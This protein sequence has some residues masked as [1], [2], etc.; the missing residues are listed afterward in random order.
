MHLNIQWP[1]SHPLG[2]LFLHSGQVLH[3]EFILA[4]SGSRSLLEI[5]SS[6]NL[7]FL[8]LSLSFLVVLLVSLLP[9]GVMAW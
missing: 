2:A 6:V 5:S 8:C 7:A 4:L 3:P 9:R 1:R